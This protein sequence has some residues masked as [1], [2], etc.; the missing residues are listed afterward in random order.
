MSGNQN[1]ELDDEYDNFATPDVDPAYGDNTPTDAQYGSMATELKNDLPEED[2]IKEAKV[3]DKYIGVRIVLDE[4]TNDG[5]N[6]ATVKRR[7]TDMH[8]KPTGTAHNNP[9]LDSREY[10]IELEDETVDR[11]FANT[12]AQN[13]YSQV[14]DEGRE[15]LAFREIIGHRANKAAMSKE[16]GFIKHA[17]GHK[18]P[19]KTTHGWEI[20][21]EFQDNTTT[22]VNL[23][24]VKE[25]SPIKLAE[26]AVGKSI[27][28][29]PVFA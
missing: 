4:N 1:F 24:D 2:E 12:I 23:R 21:V 8:G 20:E 27:D 28:D 13:L 10:E 19:K 15:I 29:E 11:I 18:K 6:L 26:Y 22:W 3:Y 16:N 5:D 9:D 14:D 17:S 25:A 7:V